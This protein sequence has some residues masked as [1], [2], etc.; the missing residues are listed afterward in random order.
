MLAKLKTINPWIAVFVFVAT[1]HWLRGAQ[2][3]AV[4]FTAASVLLILENRGKFRRLHP[5]K[6]AVPRWLIVL[7]ICVAAGI[8]FISPRHSLLDGL[9]M[10]AL[11]PVALYLVWYP[12]RGRKAAQTEPVRRAKYVWFYLILAMSLIE[13]FAFY[14]SALVGNDFDYP[15]LSIVFD[16]PLDTSWG[17]GLW[18]SLWA[19]AGVGLLRIWRRK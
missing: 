4:I 18:I 19:L 12:D 17:R 16:G 5:H 3:D 8:L 7:V 13:L 2:G 6:P 14:A 11:L 1:F 15:T 9:L 10:G